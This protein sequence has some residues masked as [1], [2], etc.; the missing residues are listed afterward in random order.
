MGNIIDPSNF[1]NTKSQGDSEKRQ[2]FTNE[3][4]WHLDFLRVWHNWEEKLNSPLALDW[5]ESELQRIN[6]YENRA[7][8]LIFSDNIDIYRVQHTSKKTIHKY[9]DKIEFLRLKSGFYDS[10]PFDFSPIDL[11]ELAQI[12]AEYILFKGWLETQRKELHEH[13]HTE[14]NNQKEINK[15]KKQSKPEFKHYFASDNPE[16]IINK[17]KEHYKDGGPKDLSLMIFAL[18]ELKY[19]H[20]DV[21]YN[22]TKLH[23]VLTNEFGHF[24]SRQAL[25]E[26]INKYLN[27][28]YSFDKAEIQQHKDKIQNIL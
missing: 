15:Q 26:Q 7:K 8:D 5:I 20:L 9:Q 21:I 2:Y 17:L 4:Q 27:S 19:I 13:K 23:E 10:R 16:A 24:G 12:Y 3:A 14:V 28:S 25:S 22:K 18:N 6:D 11:K 1:D